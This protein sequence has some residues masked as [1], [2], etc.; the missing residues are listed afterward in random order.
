MRLNAIMNFLRKQNE[1]DAGIVLGAVNRFYLCGAKTSDGILF[2]TRTE[3]F[4]LVDFRYFAHCKT[5][6]TNCQVVLLKNTKKQL[7]DL[8]MANNAAKIGLDISC[9]SMLQYQQLRAQLG[10][11]KLQDTS[12]LDKQIKAQR[13][14]KNDHETASIKE[15]QAI[16]DASFAYIQTQIKPGISEIELALKLEFYLREQGAEGVAFNPIVTFGPN[17]ALPH[18]APGNRR[19]ETGDLV[20]L[21]FGAIRNGYCSDM[22][23]TVAVAKPSHKQ[24]EIYRLVLE[25]QKKAIAAIRPGQMCC[26]IDKLARDHLQENGFGANFGHGLG[27]SIGLVPH[28]EPALTPT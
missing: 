18:G 12:A 8:I 7:N 6:V 4:L 26:A 5:A 19:L 21:D 16:V 14:I 24:Q 22:T 15:S 10:D 23:R 11:G 9:V 27:H 20:L 2:F 28:E 1:I 3:A 17:T 13:A 25:A